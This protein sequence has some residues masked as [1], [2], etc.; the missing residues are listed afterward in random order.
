MKKTK[1]GF[2]VRLYVLINITDKK[3]IYLVHYKIYVVII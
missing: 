3:T 1:L 2:I